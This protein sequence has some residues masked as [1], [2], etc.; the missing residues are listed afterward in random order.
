MPPNLGKIRIG[1]K[2]DIIP[3]IQYRFTQ[4]KVAEIN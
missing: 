3:E 2:R 1:V 4:Y